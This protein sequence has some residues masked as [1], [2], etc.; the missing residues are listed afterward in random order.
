[1]LGE[2][3]VLT[4]CGIWER[5]PLK[6][7]HFSVLSPRQF[8]RM[9]NRELT[10]LSEMSRSGNQVSEYISN[11]FLGKEC[12]PSFGVFFSFFFWL[13]EGLR[14][15]PIHSFPLWVF[16]LS[17]GCGQGENGLGVSVSAEE[18]LLSPGMVLGLLVAA[19][20]NAGVFVV[21]LWKGQSHTE[22]AAATASFSC[23][24][25]LRLRL[26]HPQ[27]VIH[28]SVQICSFCTRSQRVKGIFCISFIL[29]E[30]T[31]PRA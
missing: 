15:A 25:P 13:R 18:F 29:Q 3:P 21:T 31:A 22:L 1:M 7:S 9:L 17:N 14:A 16:S 6:K 27:N 20:C 24:L 26:N 11:T 30:L 8:K 28:C 12:T 5:I 10:H 19:L 2:P 23:L 4:M